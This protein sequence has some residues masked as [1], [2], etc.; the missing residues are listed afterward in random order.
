MTSRA[1]KV[2]CPRKTTHLNGM[3]KPLVLLCGSGVVIS[4]GGVAKV[5]W[6]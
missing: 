2:Y 1:T 3:Q 4:A 6:P 5:L